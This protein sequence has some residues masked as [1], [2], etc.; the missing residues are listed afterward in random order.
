MIDAQLLADNLPDFTDFPPGEL[1]LEG[2]G[3]GDPELL[4]LRALHALHALKMT[5]FTMPWLIR[6]SRN[7]RAIRQS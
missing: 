4:A 1:R 2:A 5:S 7:L 6:A 3:P